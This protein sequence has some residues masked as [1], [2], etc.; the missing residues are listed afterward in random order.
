MRIL[1]TPGRAGDDPRPLPPLDGIRVAGGGRR[2]AFDAERYKQRNVVER[3]FN[4]L[5]QFRG[6]AT[7]HAGQDTAWASAPTVCEHGTADAG[8]REI[9]Y[10]RGGDQDARAPS[11]D[12]GRQGGVLPRSPQRA[13]KQ[14][15]RPVVEI[16]ATGGG[17]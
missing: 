14:V 11:D 10:S 4:R 6:L 5:K 3:C 16:A 8:Q 13:T 12:V 15:L 1:I 17:R 2:P 9:R 7:R